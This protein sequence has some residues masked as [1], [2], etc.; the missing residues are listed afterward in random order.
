MC[1]FADSVTFSTFDFGNSNGG[2]TSCFRVKIVRN[3]NFVGLL[4]HP[5]WLQLVLARLGY[6]FSTIRFGYGSLKRV[7][8]SNC[9]Y[10][11][12]C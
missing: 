4:H 3:C 11:P 10:G 5:F 1:K 2:D 9:A 6:L 8:Y 7:Q 12:Y